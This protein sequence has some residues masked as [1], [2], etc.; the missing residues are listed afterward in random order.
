MSNDIAKIRLKI[1]QLEV[2]YEGRASFLQDEIFSLMKR[3]I[4]FYSEHKASIPATPLPAQTNDASSREPLGN[5]DHSTNT[6][7]A[8]LDVKKGSDLVIAAAAHLG[9]VKKK[10]TFKRHEINNEIKGATSYYKASM[11]TNLSKLLNTLV[12]GK[13]LN[14][15]TKGV[16]ALSASEKKALETKLAQ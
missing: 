5:L 6:I 3:L 4:G 10:D 11:S 1:G 9:L 16:F 8:H 12:K 2:E 14:Q 7:A 13:R 15:T